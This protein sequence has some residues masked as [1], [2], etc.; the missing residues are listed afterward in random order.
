MFGIIDHIA[1]LLPVYVLVFSRMSAMTATMPVFSFGSVPVQLR[2]MIA[3]MLTIIIAPLLAKETTLVYTSLAVLTFDVIRE[4]FIGLIIGFGTRLIFEA[5]A[6]AGS[7]V[8]M[9]MGMAIVNALDPT[10]AEQQPI[11][12]NFWALLALVFFLATNSHYFLIDVLFQNFQLIH[13]AGSKMTAALGQTLVSGGSMVFDLALKFAAPI[14]VFMI[15]VD[16]AIGFMARVMPQLNI[17]F[18]TLPL[19]IG[20]GIILLI[21]SLK[22]FQGLFSFLFNEMEVYVY[23]L[24]KGF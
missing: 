15:I 12:S 3:F 10:S 2:I 19:K 24:I 13:I 7:M 8:G 20:L 14:M 6:M 23:S 9:Q 18:V 1:Q 21:I 5:V 11:V 16:V 17:F 4:V 22:I